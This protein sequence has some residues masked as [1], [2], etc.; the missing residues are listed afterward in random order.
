MKIP[1]HYADMCPDGRHA[2][3][4]LLNQ[5]GLLYAPHL[6][7]EKCANLDVEDAPCM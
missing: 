4:S 7:Q 1:V 3:V 6:C 5:N 2:S